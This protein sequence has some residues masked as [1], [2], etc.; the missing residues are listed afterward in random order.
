VIVF[1]AAVI[2]TAAMTVAALVSVGIENRRESYR[3][4]R[5][6]AVRGRFAD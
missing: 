2:M 1:V 4:L 3:A 6:A 5:R